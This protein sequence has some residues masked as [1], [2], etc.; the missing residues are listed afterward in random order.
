MDKNNS[1]VIYL[2]HIIFRDLSSEE[3]QEE[4]WFNQYYG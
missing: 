2:D 3:K 4:L 1:D